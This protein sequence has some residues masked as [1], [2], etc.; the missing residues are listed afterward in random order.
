MILFVFI[1]PAFACTAFV[2]NGDTPFLAKNLDW[3]IDRGYLYYNLADIEKT[4]VSDPT[5]FWTARYSSISNNQFG[6]EFP[7][8][9]MNEAGLVIEELSLFGQSYAFDD[10]KHAL[11]EF[12]WVQYQLDMSASVEDVVKSLESVTIKHDIMNLHYLITDESG[13]AAVIECLDSGIVVHRG[14]TLPHP[15]LSNNPYEK[16]MRYLGFFKGY[17]GEMEVQHRP[18]SQERFVSCVHLLEGQY[19]GIDPVSYAFDLLDTVRQHDTQWQFIYDIGDRRIICYTHVNSEPY[20]ITFR[21]LKKIKHNRWAVPL[22]EERF[23]KEKMTSQEN[24]AQLKYVYENLNE[25]FPGNE[26]VY[27]KMVKAGEKSLNTKSKRQ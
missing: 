23:K 25:Y 7:L 5:L 9:G 6:K 8:G 16:A 27:E 26:H 13:D 24:E 17:G 22:F 4:S 3:E 20:E 10:S 2:I 18:G 12:Q 21:K 15:V 1:V 14:V 19:A 11:N